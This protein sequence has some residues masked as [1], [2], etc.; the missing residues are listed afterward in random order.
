MCLFW[1]LH[2]S[3]ESIK[4]DD[5][6]EKDTT[7]TTDHFLEAAAATILTSFFQKIRNGRQ[8]N[9]SLFEM[10]TNWVQQ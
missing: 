10:C 4:K 2:H 8:T 5:E 6:A 3:V 9:W 7:V 1:R